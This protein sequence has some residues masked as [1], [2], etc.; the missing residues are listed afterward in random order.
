VQQ[1]RWLGSV[2]IVALVSGTAVTPCRAQE[3]IVDERTAEAL[4]QLF[5]DSGHVRVRSAIGNYTLPL[6]QHATLSL[7]WNN[8]QVVVP[9]IHAAPGTQE[10]VDAITTASRPISGNAFSD[11]VKVRNE[12]EGGV[13]KG[14]ATVDY[15]LS[16][17]SDYVGQKLGGSW[18]RDWSD[19]LN[20]SFGTS[21]GWD[22]IEPLADDDTG[23]PPSHKTTL[24]WNAVATQ[25]VS[26]TL[27]VRYG[28][29]YNLVDGLQHNPYRNVFAG[30]ARVP[31]RHPEKRQRRDAFVRASQYLNNRSSLKLSYR[32]YDDDW[33]IDSHELGAKLSQTV[34][35][36]VFASWEYRYYT[37]T[38]AK[39]WRAE[40][41]SVDGIDGFLTGDY[42]MG[43][44]ASHL[45]GTALD[46][47]LD[48]LAPAHPTIGRFGFRC[49]YERYFN[50]NNYSANILTTQLTY[51]F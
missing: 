22:R 25:V 51:A 12:I 3:A 19:Q 49:E 5:T 38:P 42:R 21:V 2:A 33:G 27:M 20:L 6:P 11:F 35:H 50:S 40:Y 29:E 23:T 44:L 8:E 45:F 16:N 36:G 41:T 14:H 37:Q 39:F 34:T 46:V 7:H 30:G 10:A 47:S 17:E 13:R 9:A 4:M 24:H 48:G 1:L 31:E 15:Y 28:V 32:F 26:S 18:N 43:P